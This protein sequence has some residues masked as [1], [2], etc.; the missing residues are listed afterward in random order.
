MASLWYVTMFL[1]KKK[2]KKQ[3]WKEKNNFKKWS[4]TLFEIS[5]GHQLRLSPISSLDNTKE[6]QKAKQVVGTRIL[7]GTGQR[8]LAQK[9]FLKVLT[10]NLADRSRGSWGMIFHTWWVGKNRHEFINKASELLPHHL[11]SGEGHRTTGLSQSQW[12]DIYKWEK[13]FYPN[14]RGKQQRG[15]GQQIPKSQQN[16]GRWL[17]EKTVLLF[18]FFSAPSFF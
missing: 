3:K 10:N 2:L 12:R 7:K 9:A 17:T 6:S 11:Q 5:D 18:I 13:V 4:L 1:I 16:D 14:S 15:E 8:L